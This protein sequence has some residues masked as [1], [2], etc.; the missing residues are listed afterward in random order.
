VIADT[1]AL[2]ATLTEGD[3]A[4]VP[5]AEAHRE[6]LRAA[7]A[8]DP[9]IW[10]IYPMNL[11]GEAFDANFATIAA[12]PG[13]RMKAVTLAGDVIGM[14]GF[15][16]LAP[17]NRALEIGTTYLAPA[18]R[19]TGVNRRMKV[20]MIGHALACGFDRIEFRVDVRNTRSLAAVA[21]LGATREGVLRRDRVTWTGHVRD[22][23]IFSILR[24]EWPA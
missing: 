18:A 20:L 5:L 11:T 24:G 14:S 12:D 21:K 19:G 22:T 9:A 8:A 3:L 2:R 4:L 7:C 1:E 13:R 17:R 16:N 10:D 23:V 15:I 6:P